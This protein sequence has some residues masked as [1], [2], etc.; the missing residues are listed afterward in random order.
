MALNNN[1]LTTYE[2]IKAKLGLVDDTEQDLIE[3]FINNTSLTISNYCKRKF[4]EDTYTEKYIGYDDTEL[5]LNQYP[6]TVLTSATISSSSVNITDVDID[7]EDGILYYEGLWYG[8]GYTG[9]MSNARVKD[10]RNIT[11]EYTAGY[12]LPK[13]TATYTLPIAL[14]GVCENEVIFNYNNKD[15]YSSYGSTG[16]V[17]QEKLQ[18]GSVSYEDSDTSFSYDYGMSY[19]TLAVLNQYK[20]IIM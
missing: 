9:G 2:I 6:I 15:D 18:S 10:S 5:I 11:I 1:A 7:A 3:S 8:C 20:K 14:K 12:T 4:Q 16:K 19:Q 13:D 17:S